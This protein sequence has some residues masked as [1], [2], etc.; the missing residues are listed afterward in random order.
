MADRKRNPGRCGGRH[1]RRK[2]GDVKTR[3]SERILR[4]L[5]LLGI[6]AGLGLG[7]GMVAGC[8]KAPPLTADQATAMIQ[9]RY[10]ATPATGVPIVVNKLGL[11]MGLTDGYWKLTRVYPNKFWADYV[12]T[13]EGKKAIAVP[14]SG[15]VIEWRPD[16]MTSTGYAVMVQTMTA[17]H[18]KAMAVQD[19]VSEELP[20][21]ET[22]RSVQYSEV[23]DLTGVPQG[24]K[25]IAEN[26]GNEL[27][28]KRQADFALVDGKWVLKSVE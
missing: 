13:D 18:L 16:S 12:L 4:T 7:L 5:A 10:D 9:A 26:P 28:T 3:I 21:A 24:L 15:D 11:K 6:A 1:E 22:A 27:S 8:R 19:P 25:D 2:G 17:N 23:V 14:G 20:G